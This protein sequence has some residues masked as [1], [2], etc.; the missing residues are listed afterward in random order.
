MLWVLT[1]SGW[2]ADRE[3]A[4]EGK[5]YGAG[6][7]SYPV[8]VPDDVF[9]DRVAVRLVIEAGGAGSVDDLDVSLVSPLGTTV[10]LLAA[11]VLGDEVGFL[12]GSRLEGAL[13]SESG[14]DGIESGTAPYVGT[15]RVDNWTLATGLG[16]F[17][18]QR[19]VGSWTLRIR[20]AVGF[21]GAVFGGANRS[22]AGWSNPGSAL[23]MT[24]LEAGSE[25]PS[26]TAASDTGVFSTDG[27]TRI[28]TPTLTGKAAAGA[29][30]KIQYGSG[31]LTVIGTVVAGGDGVWT[32][33]VPSPLAPG[34]HD[35][36]ALV[37]HPTDSSVTLTG[38]KTVV[39]DTTAPTVSELADQT[40]DEGADTDLVRFLV[41]DNLTA[42]AGL[43]VGSGSSNAGLVGEI[44]S[45]GSGTA[46]NVVVKP[47]SGRSGSA[48]ITVTVTDLAG[49][50][51]DRSFLL[52]VIPGNK[53]P[54][55]GADVVYRSAGGR[56]VK[57]LLSDLLAN[58]TDA[59]GDALSIDS[60]QTALPD[61]AS[62]KLMEPYVVYM[63]LPGTDSAGSFEYVLSDGLGGHRLT[64]TVPVTVVSGA[65]QDEPARPLM[66]ATDKGDVILTWIGVA[67]RNY[68]V[69]YTTSQQAPYTWNDHTTPAVYTAARTGA[70]GVFR[71]QEPMT[72][73]PVRLYRAIPM[74]W[75]NDAPVLG[76]DRVERSVFLREIT[77]K[78]STL[79]AN[80]TDADGDALSV[81]SVS[82]ALP[83][84]ATVELFGDDI[85]YT[86]SSGAAEGSEESFQYEVSD[87]L[88]GHRVS[89][90]V[91]IK[92]IEGGGP[93]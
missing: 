82:G 18:N 51:T 7:T 11:T 27:V 50:G 81:V 12:S 10:K 46:R 33:T 70:L 77:F 20:D 30:V 16:K 57:V 54:V 61:G 76:E 9:L 3:Y 25:P 47:A 67:R 80:D 34:S 2:A 90:T 63:A 13:F 32:F 65:G 23:I 53:A 72:T 28:T 62:V 36:S 42:A 8:A 58:D 56:V 43:T 24:P 71:H 52:T 93:P 66:A 44:V 89:G 6:L 45:G 35:F 37:T 79:L 29:T 84:G 21:G 22:A 78:A 75:A 39:V 59:D 40:I 85:T 88:G 48:L 83:A 64:N 19:S 15:F 87:G 17:R 68:K 14:T 91:R 38:T 55:A 74:G 26:L 1:V 73:G 86:V 69:Q 4:I 60:V 31:S 92:T 5:A 41:S 49:N